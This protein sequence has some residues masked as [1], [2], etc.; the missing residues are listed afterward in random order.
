MADPTLREHSP[1]NCVRIERIKQHAK[2]GEQNHSDAQWLA[3]LAEEFG[4]VGQCV[5]KCHVDAGVEENLKQQYADLLEYE[6]IQVAAVCV[7][8]VECIRRRENRAGEASVDD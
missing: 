8:W 7:Q 1:I 5:C 4:E 2:W 6:L 3:V